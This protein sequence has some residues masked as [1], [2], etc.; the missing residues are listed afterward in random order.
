MENVSFRDKGSEPNL[1]S[2]MIKDLPVDKPLRFHIER[3]GK[4][5]DVWIKLMMVSKD[6]RAAFQK[7]VNEKLGR[8][9]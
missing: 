1:F 8:A 7:E 4:R 2:E 3:E 5:F 9:A 6:Q